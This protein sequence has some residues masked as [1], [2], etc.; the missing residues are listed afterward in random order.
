MKEQR[1]SEDQDILLLKMQIENLNAQIE[2]KD[3]ELEERRK[4]KG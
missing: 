3:R 2:Q 4:C 1:E